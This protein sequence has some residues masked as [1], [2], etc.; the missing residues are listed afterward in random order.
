MYT[1][2]NVYM[3]LSGLLTC[4]I[5]SL[6]FCAEIHVPNTQPIN[7][8]DVSSTRYLLSHVMSYCLRKF[9]LRSLLRI[10]L[11]DLGLHCLLARFQLQSEILSAFNNLKN[12]QRVFL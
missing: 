9:W 12:E 8:N 3:T 11:L 5:F 1:H 4:S 6:I 7:L 2:C 10:S